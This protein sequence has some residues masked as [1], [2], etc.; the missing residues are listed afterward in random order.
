MRIAIIGASG[1]LGRH[2]VQAAV[3]A[4]H[5]V[6]AVGRSAKS[7]GPLTQA[8]IETRLGDMSDSR[9]LTQAL[10]GVEAVIN[11]AGYYP[12][13]PRPWQSEV[14]FATRDMRAFYEV[15]ATL[16]L[17]KIV[18]LGAAIAL[19]RDPSGRPGTEELDYAGRPDNLNP[20]LQVK[21]ALDKQARA[22]AEQGLPV[23]V[24]IPSETGVARAP[25]ARDIRLLAKVRM[26]VGGL[27]THVPNISPAGYEFEGDQTA[28]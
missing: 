21:W 5:G 25:Q 22:Y 3:A 24:G 6:V 2:T 11:C 15:C 28:I 27:Q 16:P 26:A 20:Y 7:L 4:G 18:Y 12:T 9:S 1:M 17:S 13:L 23:V 8:G 10:Q 19:P 14:E